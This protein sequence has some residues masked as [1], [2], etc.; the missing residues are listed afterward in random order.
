M[1][2]I[3]V[4]FVIIIVVIISQLCVCVH[5]CTCAIVFLFQ[6]FTHSCVNGKEHCKWLRLSV[7]VIFSAAAADAYFVLLADILVLPSVL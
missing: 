2:N 5:T 4:I 6:W 7:P 1:L 3:Y